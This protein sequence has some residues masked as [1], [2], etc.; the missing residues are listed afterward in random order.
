M[1]LSEGNVLVNGAN[2]FYRAFGTGEPVF[3]LHGGPGFDHT[4]LEPH[5]R[6]LC[7]KNTVFFYDQ[8]GTGNSSATPGNEALTPDVFADDLDA[9]RNHF[10]LKRI[11]LLGHSWGGLLALHYATKHPD[12][13][14][15]IVVISP[16][17]IGFTFFLGF[18]LRRFL[19]FRPRHVAEFV[20]LIV[21]KARSADVETM[22]KF[23]KLNFPAYFFDSQLAENLILFQ[24]PSTA[25][26][27]F[28][29]NRMIVR[30]LIRSDLYSRLSNV[31]CPTLI[32]HGRE[33]VSQVSVAKKIHGLIPHSQFICFNECGH[34]P[35]IEKP[36][37]FHDAVRSFWKDNALTE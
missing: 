4:Y 17:G 36:S 22:R 16:M 19:W 18:V 14:K 24:H 15:L 2:I 12:Q 31:R 30:H 21:N 27:F 8:R 34:F 25:K 35:F 33:D 32:L 13:V 7:E 5:L 29:I 20:S 1:Q 23:E 3:V 6:G 28:T 9:L 10:T 11:N 26:N 37:E